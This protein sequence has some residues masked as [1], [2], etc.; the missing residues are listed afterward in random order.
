MI[1]PTDILNH[2]DKSNPIRAIIDL[3]EINNYYKYDYLKSQIKYNKMRITDKIPSENTISV[4][5]S[6]IDSHVREL[7]K[8]QFPVSIGIHCTYGNNLSGFFVIIYL[9]EFQKMT[10]DEAIQTFNEARGM[11][12]EKE[13]YIEYLEKRFD[14]S[15]N[16]SSK[17]LRNILSTKN[18]SMKDN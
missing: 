3:N 7:K 1:H 18:E 16:D 17:Q 2:Y 9:V 6:I 12:F 4:V 8:L 15:K 13:N 11:D 10:L 5:T 14:T